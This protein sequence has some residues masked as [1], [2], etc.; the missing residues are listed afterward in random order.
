MSLFHGALFH[1]FLGRH[2]L[3]FEK[4]FLDVIQGLH[5]MPLGFYSILGLSS[6]LYTSI[7]KIGNRF[8][9]RDQ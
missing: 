8:D 2:R 3:G 5:I 7:E 1:F 4:L 6:I 9:D